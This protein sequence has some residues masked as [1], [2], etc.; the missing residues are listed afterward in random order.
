MF[1]DLKILVV[2][3]QTEMRSLIRN[4]LAEAGVTQVFEA[5]D[6]RAALQFIDMAFDCVNVI[7]CDWN[8][9]GL[10]GVELLRQIRSTDTATPVLMLT[11]RHDK[12]SVLE[13][14]MAGVTAYIGKPFSEG[15]LTSKLRILRERLKHA[16]RL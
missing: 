6:G 9:P 5:S 4:I 13:A 15:Q 10:S 12:R 11:A 3:D 8:M 1:D 16:G 14:K 2:E 7:I